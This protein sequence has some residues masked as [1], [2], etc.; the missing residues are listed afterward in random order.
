MRTILNHFPNVL[1]S[2]NLFCGCVAVVMALDGDLTTATWCIFAA[3]VFDFFDGFVARLLKAQ[4]ALGLQLDSLADM[5]SFGVAPSAIVFY[6]LQVTQ[7]YLTI[8]LPTFTP[9][10]AFLIAVFSAL[11]LAK[12]NIDERQTTGFI[13]LPTPASTLF[14]CGLTGFNIFTVSGFYIVLSCVPL[15]CFLLVCELPMFSLKIKRTPNFITKYRLQ[16]LL[17]TC[18]IVSI[19]VW[20]LKGIT[21]TI[22]IYILLSAFKNIRKEIQL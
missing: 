19:A 16:L 14:F 11:R 8:E 10:I 7:R 5:V 17:I 2:G 13:G 20:R 4:S 9:Y 18:A 6:I 12:F 22:I 21:I 15:F 3:A 1:T